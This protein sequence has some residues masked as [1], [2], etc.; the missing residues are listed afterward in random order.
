MSPAHTGHGH[1]CPTYSV[2]GR[3]LKMREL[4]LIPDAVSPPTVTS[5]K[6]TAHLNPVLQL[7]GMSCTLTCFFATA[8]DLIYHHRSFLS[9]LSYAFFFFI[10]EGKGATSSDLFWTS[11][12]TMSK[13]YIF[14]AWSNTANHKCPF[15]SSVWLPRLVPITSFYDTPIARS[16]TSECFWKVYWKFNQNRVFCTDHYGLQHTLVKKSVFLRVRTHIVR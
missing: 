11:Q 5:D 12:S 15:L 4:R 13:Q 14:L 3:E 9:T 16:L 6:P 7:W 10:F 1:S 8:D 2:F